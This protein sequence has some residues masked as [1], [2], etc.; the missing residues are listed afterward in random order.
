MGSG[1][2]KGEAVICDG[3]DVLVE[4]NRVFGNPNS[5]RYKQA[6]ANNQFGNVP[7]AADNYLKL[8][9]AYRQAGLVV[10]AGWE[11]YLRFLGAADPQNIY[12]IAQ[13]RYKG[14]T[15]GKGMSTIIH[16]GGRVR[17]FPGAGIEPDVIDSP[18]PLP[19]AKS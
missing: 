5:H 11:A 7:N 2:A 6:Q 8:V 9:D 12:D 18:C 14:L 1:V 13:F 16:N 3:D 19:Q 4:L 10:P 15:Q 17:T